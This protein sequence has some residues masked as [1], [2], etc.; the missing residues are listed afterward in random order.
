MINLFT[1]IGILFG[2]SVVG[3]SINSM[4]SSLIIYWS[5]AS[6]GIILGGLTAVLFMSYRSVG[7]LYLFHTIWY[8]LTK[9]A[10]KPKY[11]ALRFTNY[12]KIV[13]NGGFSKLDNE[14]SDLKDHTLEKESLE[15]L[16][17][18]YS[19]EDLKY[20]IENSIIEKM[21]RLKSNAQLVK[22]LSAYAPAFGMIG[23]VIGLIAMLHDM[24][25]DIASIGPAMSVA[26]ITTLYGVALSVVI[27]NP[28]SEKIKKQ[29]ELEY[30]NYKIIYDGIVFL[31]EKKNYI[32]MRDALNAH[33]LPKYKLGSDEK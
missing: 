30:I 32:F 31:Y 28:I 29:F 5:L 18:G 1:I 4:A 10:E 3:L 15:M 25:K 24:G 33:L 20:I 9:P 23:T 22:N 14:I 2:F 11:T 21:D 12:A 16:I 6:I 26:L 19:K 13:M 27:F 17:A 8:V 7:V